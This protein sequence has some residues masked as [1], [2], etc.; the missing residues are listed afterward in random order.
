MIFNFSVKRIDSA[1]F[2]ILRKI[3][4]WPLVNQK[5]RCSFH[6]LVGKYPKNN[7]F[8][9]NQHNLNW[10]IINKKSFKLKYVII[11]FEKE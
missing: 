9:S 3:E 7:N 6:E 4:N 1:H 8:R 2:Y 11:N 5:Q 10:L